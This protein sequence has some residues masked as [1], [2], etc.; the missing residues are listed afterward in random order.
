V[1]LPTADLLTPPDMSIVGR[2]LPAEHPCRLVG[3]PCHCAT[4]TRWMLG[5][6]WC[7]RGEDGCGFERAPPP[8]ATAP[9]CDCGEAAKWLHRRWWCARSG[10]RHDCHERAASIGHASLSR[11][12]HF[13]AMD[14]ST[15][16]AEPLLIETTTIDAEIA[17][18]VALRKLAQ[19][20]HTWVDSFCCIAPT[21]D[22]CG[23]GL[24]ARTAL[25]RHQ[26]QRG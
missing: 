23:I 8:D 21:D 3:R 7:A 6:W 13:T 9:L 14:D 19:S 24:F 20:K 12:C 22:G 17:G 1:P 11:A 5:R 2:S 15:G 10:E 4:P 16:R 25:E 26:V 18:G